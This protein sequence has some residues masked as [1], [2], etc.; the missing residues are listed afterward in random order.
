MVADVGFFDG[1]L[2]SIASIGDIVIIGML[3]LLCISKHLVRCGLVVLFPMLQFLHAFGSPGSHP[4]LN[5]IIL[6]LCLTVIG[7]NIIGSFDILFL[8]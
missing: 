2:F 7:I 3:S 8:H 1:S 6:L 4:I 5:R